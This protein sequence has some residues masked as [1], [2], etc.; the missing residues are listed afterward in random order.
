MQISLTPKEL[1]EL[2]MSVEGVP[3]VM[4]QVE[5]NRADACLQGICTALQQQAAKGQ[6]R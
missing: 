3:Q 4:Q 5:Q 2:L 1:R 6:T